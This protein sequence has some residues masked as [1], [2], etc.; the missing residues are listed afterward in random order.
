M[1]SGQGSRGASHGWMQLSS[2]IVNVIKKTG[3]SAEMINPITEETVTTTGSLF[4]D[5]ANLIVW[6]D[7]H[8]YKTTKELRGK[9]R[10]TAKAWA[11]LLRATGGALKP[12]KCF[13][14]LIGYVCENG[15][16]RYEDTEGTPMPVLGDDNETTEIP[17]LS[18]SEE[19]KSLGVFSAQREAVRSS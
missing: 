7:R 14:W 12:I 5:D 4:V 9:V 15:K 16:W 11:C 2:V 10:S 17:S 19:R 6:G 1:G 3:H 13:W 8:N 18:T